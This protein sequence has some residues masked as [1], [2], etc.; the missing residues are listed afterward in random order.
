MRHD[1][2]LQQHEM[3]ADSS[4]LVTGTKIG[5]GLARGLGIKLQYR[6]EKGDSVTRGEST[7]SVSSA[8]SYI[9]DEPTAGEWLRSIVPG[10]AGVVSYLRSLFPFTT[11]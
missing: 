11:W 8:D 1:T 10:R 2:A 6:N 3:F 9:E 5:H 4:Y 7:Y